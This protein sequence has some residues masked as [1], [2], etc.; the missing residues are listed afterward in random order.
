MKMTGNENVDN[1][2][3]AGVVINGVVRNVARWRKTN[4]TI[5][6]K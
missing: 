4:G 3:A 5:P 6:N 2:A 1:I